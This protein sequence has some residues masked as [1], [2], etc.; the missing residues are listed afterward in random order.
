MK[1]EE[2]QRAKEEFVEKYGYSHESMPA[3]CRDD[4]D[5]LFKKVISGND[6]GYPMEFVNWFM[7]SKLAEFF[8]RSW[9]ER[10]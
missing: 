6:K 10:K 8:Y 4:L 1:T 3:E 2:I 7:A 9:R 5:I